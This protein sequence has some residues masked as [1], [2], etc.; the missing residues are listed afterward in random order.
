MREQI[1]SGLSHLDPVFV[2]CYGDVK[3]ANR[4]HTDYG[5]F[6]VKKVGHRFVCCLTCFE[7][8]PIGLLTSLISAP[9]SSLQE[10]DHKLRNHDVSNSLQLTEK[11]SDQT[12][13]HSLSYLRKIV[14]EDPARHLLSLLNILNHV[15]RLAELVLSSVGMGNQECRLL[16]TALKHVDK[17]RILELPHTSLGHGISE[18][19]KHLHNV[20]HLKELDLNDSQMGEEEVTALAQSLKNVTQLSKLELS[21]NPLGQG[22][23]E[24]AK[25]LHSVPH[26]KKLYLNDT[27][28][29]E[30]EVTALAHSLK[31]VTQLSELELSNNPLGHGISELAKRLHSVPHLNQLTLNDTQMGEEEVTALAHSLKNVTQLS[32][33]VL[34]EN[35]LGDGVNELAKH[36]HSVPHLERLFLNDTQMGEEE[37]TALAHSLKN[38]T[39]LSELH[40][41]NNP[42]GQGISEFT[43]HLHNV[44]HLKKLHLDDTQMGVEEVTAL[45]HR[46]VNV[47][48][49]KFLSLGNN[50]LGRG[51]TEL[52]RCL[53]SSPQLSDLSLEKVQLTKKEATELCTLA[54]ERNH[55][56][57]PWRS[58]PHSTSFVTNKW[59]M[60]L[61][62]DYHVSF[63]FVIPIIDARNTQEL[64][65]RRKGTVLQ[66]SCVSI[67]IHTKKT[68]FCK[69]KLVE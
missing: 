61:K 39:Q 20:P 63:S 4:Y 12:L 36:L 38:V 53:R 30:E 68:Q 62:S 33:L 24:L 47:P 43:K 40:L 41:S 9:E 50:P 7:Y 55:L 8:E 2:T 42:L 26:L 1:F 48:E 57:D 35:P 23:G 56:M 16:A 25:H 49:L 64:P 34:S 60:Y 28:M 66:R 58:F 37:V 6:F 45:A 59:N 14:I 11:T 54:N 67:L 27:E 32:L 17:L 21:N 52:I 51:V 65:G 69:R 18:L 29:G 13:T 31:N 5:D 22:V 10:P 15:P 19:A 3:S 44:P 46:L